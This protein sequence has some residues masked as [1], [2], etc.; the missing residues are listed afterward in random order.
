[1]VDD[2]LSNNDYYNKGGLN[3]KPKEPFIHKRN[4]LRKYITD[5]CKLLDINTDQSVLG[6]NCLEFYAVLSSTAKNKIDYMEGYIRT[7][8]NARDEFKQECNSYKQALK[9]IEKQVKAMNNEC[10]YDDICDCNNCDMKNGCSYYR[11]FNILG[12]INGVKEW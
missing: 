11:K 3:G 10:F 12:I 5:I 9:E 7:L 1:M 4:E 2:F 6:A 8:E